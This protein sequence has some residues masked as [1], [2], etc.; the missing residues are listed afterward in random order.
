MKHFL[1]AVSLMVVLMGSAAYAEEPAAPAGTGTEEAAAAAPAGQAGADAQADAQPV[2]KSIYD[3]ENLKPRD[4]YNMA[5]E[6]LKS[7]TFE[8]A[9]EGFGRAR[10]LAAID[11]ELRYAS[12][13]NLAHTYA[14]KAASAGDVN[15]LDEG[16]LN[17]VIEDL[18]M[19]VVW[20]RDAVRQRPGV[21]EAS[22]NLEIVL[23][24]LI[25]AKDVLAQ[26]YNTLERQLDA[27]LATE[28]TI[29]ENA[30]GLSEQILGAKASH[31]PQGYRDDF[32]TIAKVQREA[33]TQTNLVSE[34]L[35]NALA[36]IEEVPE[37]QRS[38]EDAYRGYQ[39][40]SASP[41][42][43][44][45]RQAMAGART[46][47]RDLSMENALRLTNRAFNL[48][49]QA[50]EQL[51]EPLAVLGHIAEDET[52]F[53]RIAGAKN[54]FQTPELLE[55]LKKQAQRDDVEEPAWLNNDLLSDTQIDV[56]L[57]TNRVIAFLNAVTQAA[58]KQGDAA[59]QGQNQEQAEAAKAQMEQIREALPFIQKAAEWM[60]QATQK[61]ERL[62]Y[63]GAEGD[64]LKSLE[65][66]S[67]A[68]ERFADL[69]HLIEIAYASQV[70]IQT[71]VRGETGGEGSE[72][73]SRA[74]QREYLRPL[75]SS[76]I[77]RL[78]RLAT[79]LAKEAAKANE[80][81]MKQG[82]AQGQAG[83]QGGPSE[84]QM[85]Q[86][87]QLFEHAENLRNTAREALV[88]MSAKAGQTPE[89]VVDEQGNPVEVDETVVPTDIQEAVW[90]D[91]SGDA[92]VAEQSLEELRILFFTVIEHVQELL[93]QQ[94]STMDQTTDVSTASEEE[95][96][97]KVPAVVDRQRVHEVTSDKL[98]E[99]LT[100]QAEE[101][102]N[103]GGQ[104]GMQ[105]GVDP[106]EIAQRYRQAASELQ[107]A[108][109]DMRQVQKDLQAEPLLFTEALEGQKSA[110]EH[111]AKALEYLQPPQQ[112]QQ[113]Q[114]QQDQEQQQQ[115]QQQ[116]MSKEQ[117][118]KKIQQIKSRD[119]ERRRTKET[120]DSGMDV[121]EK[122]W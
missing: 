119:K 11:N 6:Q 104:Q 32:K 65:Q 34:N 9:I 109:T 30:R 45:A 63:A 68:M 33:L 85:Q 75:L 89:A 97:L 25:N 24:R 57:R 81:M 40:K 99:V 16:A 78:E 39:L 26:K 62:D 105:Q 5:L 31:D 60:Q 74:Q 110:S 12:A 18:T 117:A 28:R 47:L 77:E 92:L 61:L 20:F 17:G 21:K 86:M 50:R 112:Q 121:V 13:Y 69:K 10:D 93:K 122:D 36:K 72:L 35:D 108:S 14:Q 43:E 15:G 116:K 98:A 42:L 52:G 70:K 27:I 7:Q 66:L 48:V 2:Q 44:N 53:V 80:Q 38:Q 23:K 90:S 111:I 91:L 96:G 113:Q 1:S 19:S 107:V 101:I 41:L 83:A 88:R 103:Q 64:G 54:M 115:Q 37:E 51:E 76:N 95:K 58:A 82:G 79:L 114:Q 118:D 56:L 87:Q 4:I 8:M 3:D 55:K 73:L 22:G 84:E 49:K 46:Q 106:A 102:Q 67:L 120:K 29:R 94:M 71:L 100:K 59:V